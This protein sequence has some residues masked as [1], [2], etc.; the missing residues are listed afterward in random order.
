MP[1]FGQTDP[2]R[3]QANVQESSGQF[4]ADASQPI[5]PGCELD[6]ACLLGSFSPVCLIVLAAP[7]VW[8][9]ESN[10]SCTI[11]FLFL[12]GKKR[13]NMA[14]RPRGAHFRNKT[15][16]I[17]TKVLL[18]LKILIKQY[19]TKHNISHNNNYFLYKAKE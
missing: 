4:V 2:V 7:C 8:Q 17:T 18:F 12:V 5:W 9:K 14:T 19:Q 3:K 11:H 1:G 15:T 16:K 6:P 13:A 10:T